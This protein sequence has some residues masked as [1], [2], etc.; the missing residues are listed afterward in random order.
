MFDEAYI[1]FGM[2]KYHFFYTQLSLLGEVVNS[3]GVLSDPS[4]VKDVVNYLVPQIAMQVCSFVALVNYYSYFIPDFQVITSPLMKLTH[5]D[6]EFSWIE[7]H[8]NAFN[9][10]WTVI[11]HTPC[12]MRPELLFSYCRHLGRYKGSTLSGGGRRNDTFRRIL[13]L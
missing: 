3:S 5:K 6:A 11:I 12:L 13:F 4:L 10:L 2:E 7:E 8:V 1:K 9:A